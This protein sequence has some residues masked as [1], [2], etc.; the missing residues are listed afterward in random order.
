MPTMLE[1]ARPRGGR[2]RRVLRYRVRFLKD[3][4]N[5]TGYRVAACQASFDVEAAEQRLAVELAKQQLCAARRI[6]DW[7][8][9]ADR[10]EVDQV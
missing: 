2:D 1:P 9:T 7:R 6:T 5:S 10:V 8:I 3:L 4:A